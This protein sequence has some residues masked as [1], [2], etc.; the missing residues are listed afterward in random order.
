LIIYEIGDNPVFEEAKPIGKSKRKRMT[1]TPFKKGVYRW[2]LS[3]D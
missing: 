2:S 1:Y 3:L